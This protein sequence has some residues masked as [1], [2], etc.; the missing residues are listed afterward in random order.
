MGGGLV[1]DD[2]HLDAAAQ[3][4]GQH[5][6]AVA[7]EPDRQRLALGL[8]RQAQVQ[9]GV[10]VFGHDVE[11][12]GLDPPRQP[13]RV[14]VDDQAHAVV[15]GHGERLR[16]A[17]AAAPAGHG[18][19]AGQG[20]AEPLRRDGRERL[21]GALQ[22]ALG[23][24]VDPRPGGHLPVH[25]SARPPPGGGTPASWPSRRPGSSWRSAPAAPTRGC[26]SRRPACRTG[27]AWSRPRAARSAC[28]TMA[29]NAA[30]DRAARPVPPYTTRSSG[31]SAT[32]GSRLFISMRSGASVCQDRAV[33]VVPRGARTVRAPSM[34][35][36]PFPPRR[37][38]YVCW[39][40]RAGPG[41]GRCAALLPVT[42][43][44]IR[45]G[46]RCHSSGPATSS[47]ARTA[48]PLGDV[49]RRPPRSPGDR[50]RSAVGPAP[51]TVCSGPG[52][53]PARRGGGRGRERRAQVERAGG[54]EQLD[55][56]HPGQPVERAA[57]LA[58]RRPAHG[59][60]VLLHGRRRDRVDARRARRAAS[61]RTRWRPACTGRSCGR[62]RRPGRRRGTAAGRASGRRRASGR[63]A[64]RRSRR[65]RRRRWRGSRA[66]RRRARRGSC[67]WTPPGRPSVTTGLSMALA[68]SMSATALACARVSRAAPCTCGEQRSEYASCT[69]GVLGAAVAG[70]DGGAGQ[71]RPQ[72]GGGRGLPGVRAQRLQ[73]GV[74]HRVGAE[75]RLDATSRR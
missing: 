21:V 11:V 64:A 68:S 63:C 55:G 39:S 8:G 65:G 13:H 20:A 3:Q 18:Q 6:R 36:V 23:A 28:A 19:R 48:A 59:H 41:V 44:I 10:Q 66:R 51:S 27:P 54:G 12:P 37:R 62:S 69:A 2:V 42:D 50:K 24:D 26:G 73:A 58:R 74:E 32:S 49:R 38:Q 46:A 61:A 29:S 43:S 9:R 40:V 71:Q 60:V 47:A 56:Q 35:I 45:T 1:G 15:Q 72:V 17:H 7:D 25:R 67:R 31:R 57:Q 5:G 22:D 70:D 33:S 53:R 16:A 52:G 30:Q 14:D 34:I 4:L 75:Q